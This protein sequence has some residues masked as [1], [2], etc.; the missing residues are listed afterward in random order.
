MCSTC[1]TLHS[2]HYWH[3]PHAPLRG[4]P[5]SCTSRRLLHASATLERRCQHVHALSVLVNLDCEIAAL[6]LVA[7]EL[8]DRALHVRFGH[9]PHSSVPLQA[10][11]RMS[12][13]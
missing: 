1:A 5:K 9:E 8:L 6:E 12:I 10:V 4:P 2:T 7:T 11:T 13:G 3:P